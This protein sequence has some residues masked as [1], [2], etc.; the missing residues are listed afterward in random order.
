MRNLIGE[1][2]E[3]SFLPHE[4]LLEFLSSKYNYSI[5]DLDLVMSGSNDTYKVMAKDLISYLRIYKKG[6][7]NPDE[8]VAELEIIN[9]LKASKIKV[10]APIRDINQRFINELSFKEG[11]RSLVLFE[12]AEGGFRQ[13][14]EKLSEALGRQVGKMHLLLDNMKPV[15]RFSIRRDHLLIEPLEILDR[16]LLEAKDEYQFLYKIGDEVLKNV[17]SKKELD[18]G[19]IHGDLHSRNVFFDLENSPCLFDFDC[20]GYG[21]RAY[22]IAV[23]VFNTVPPNLQ[24]ETSLFKRKHLLGAFLQGYRS[25]R[26]LNSDDE[27]LI[28]SFVV[29]KHIWQ[30]AMVAGMSKYNDTQ[31]NFGPEYFRR[32]NSFIKNWIDTQL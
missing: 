10:A 2:V 24:D 26:F 20:C 4:Q 22:E 7:R 19:L 29:L 3:H 15:N 27:Q 28:N 8:I 13:M 32:C 17:E 25:E 23:F 9:Y 11:V 14:D 5:S 1:D 18:F 31:K 21:Y 12:S 30:I 6:L 16:F